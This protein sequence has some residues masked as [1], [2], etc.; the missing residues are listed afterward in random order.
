MTDTGT[1]APTAAYRASRLNGGDSTGEA[2]AA[3]DEVASS[4]GTQA[5]S[6]SAAGAYHLG[7]RLMEPW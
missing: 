7:P 2:A 6:T 5:A 3:D 1:L 4:A